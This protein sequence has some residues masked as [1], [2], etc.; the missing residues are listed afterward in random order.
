MADS[1][2]YTNSES[3]SSDASNTLAAR[4]GVVGTYR[5]L[6]DLT[7]TAQGDYTR[8]QDLF[9]TLGI[10]HSVTTLNPTG[11]GLSPTANPVAYNQFSGTASVQKNFV[12]SFVSL[13]GSIVDLVYDD[14]AGAPSAN[15]V[16]YTG[17]GR[18]GYWFVPALY[19]YVE[20]SGDTRNYDTSSLNSSG[21]RATVG[22]GSDQIGLF[23]G[24][25]YG[26]YQSE[27]YDSSAI[28]TVNGAVFGGRGYY[29]VLPEL[30][31][32]ASLD[33]SIGNSLEATAPGSSAGTSTKVTTLY[34]QANYSIAPEWTASG[35]GGYINTDYIH[36]VRTDNAWIVGG[37]LTYSVWNNLGLTLD[38]SH[39]ELSSNVPFQSYT[40]DVVT[41]GVSYK[42]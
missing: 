7:L 2:I 35:R 22:I 19:A 30:T 29:Y 33:E 21:Y 40:R 42:Y 39:I 4:A 1:R 6:P 14:N 13:S 20:L 5:P 36:N 27:I 23:K 8:Q 17:T 37:T 18:A 31:L 28:G 9:S 15:G 32:S 25:I 41:F 12:D 16:T 10:D 34:G 38:Y 3:S 24:E 26:G 11:V